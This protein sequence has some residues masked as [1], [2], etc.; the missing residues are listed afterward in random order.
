MNMDKTNLK[1]LVLFLRQ[2]FLG[3]NQSAQ[4]LPCH[5]VTLHSQ[6]QGIQHIS[7]NPGDELGDADLTP[8]T[9]NMRRMTL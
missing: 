9:P 5:V 2:D 8:T 3:H 6:E 1:I 4:S 7:N